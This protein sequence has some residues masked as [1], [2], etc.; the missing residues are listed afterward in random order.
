MSEKT[1]DFARLDERLANFIKQY[2]RDRAETKERYAIE[3]DERNVWRIS[4]EEKMDGLDAKIQ[5]VVKDHQLIISIGKWFAGL[6][7]AAGVL[8]KAWLELRGKQ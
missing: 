3:R 4:I 1:E 7:G 8:Y 6:L 5:P 2:D